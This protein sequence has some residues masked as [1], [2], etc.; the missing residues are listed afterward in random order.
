[1]TDPRVTSSIVLDISPFKS[2]KG[3]KDCYVSAKHPL[4]LTLFCG[5]K[6]LN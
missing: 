3:G 4:Y 6:I 1:M 5:S 2:R